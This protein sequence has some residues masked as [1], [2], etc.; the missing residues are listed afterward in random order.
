MAVTIYDI[1]REA[2]VGIG[3]VSRVVNNHPS[4]SE[5]TKCRVLKVAGRLKYHPHPYARGLARKRTNSFLV[6]VPFFTTYF[7]V[8]ILHGAQACLHDA[9]GDLI[10]HGVAHPDHAEAS[11]RRVSNRGR[12][13]GILY[14][15]MRL[16]EVF[17]QEV[18][19]LKMPLVLVDAFH[20]DFD[21]FTVENVEGS[22]S[23]TLHL[24]Q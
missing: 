23:A 3:T 9:D 11:L 13:D 10:L 6:V 5:E 15:S 21:A 17:A 14:F 12:F 1:A 22:R 16:P 8:E 19:Q 24:V 18:R 7:F 20:P 4:V 2:Q